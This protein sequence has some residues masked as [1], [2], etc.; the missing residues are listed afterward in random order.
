[1]A[2]GIFPTM[3]IPDIIGA[4]AGWGLSVS[5]EQLVRPSPDFVEGVYCAC[6]QQVTDL[7]HDSLRDPVQNALS[8]TDVDRVSHCSLILSSISVEIP[9][10][11]YAS[12]LVQNLV[13]Y[14]LYVINISFTHFN[15]I[16][17]H[18]TR[19]ARAA[20]VEDFSAKDISH[21]ERDRTL[22]FLS[23]FINFVKF[24]EQFCNPFIKELRDRSDTMIVERDQVSK[25]L[26]EVQQKIEL[27][28]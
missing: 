8:V 13:L 10:D 5:H 1:M 19:F 6:L 20:K 2:K 3:S 17:Y 27:M 22:T 15:S 14:H 26:A 9:Q 24:T 25:E 21:P 16:F 12:A 28:K 4:L 11:L 18:S 23:A 7:S